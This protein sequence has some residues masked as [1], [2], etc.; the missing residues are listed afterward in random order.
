MANVAFFGLFLFLFYFAWAIHFLFIF[1]D[2]FACACMLLLY[3]LFMLVAL[4]DIGGFFFPFHLFQ[5]LDKAWLAFTL[6]KSELFGL[7]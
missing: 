1:L 2:I 5:N 3:I 7:N 6:N 4:L